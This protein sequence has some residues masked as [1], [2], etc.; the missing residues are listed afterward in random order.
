MLLGTSDSL[1]NTGF[2]GF[3]VNHSGT[4]Y[5]LPDYFFERNTVEDQT[6]NQWFA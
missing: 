4:A 2:N 1:H 6:V 3:P 5:F